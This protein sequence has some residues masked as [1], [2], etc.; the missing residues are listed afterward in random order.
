MDT[1]ADGI[2]AIEVVRYGSTGQFTTQL[3]ALQS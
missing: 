3:M 2:L 1:C